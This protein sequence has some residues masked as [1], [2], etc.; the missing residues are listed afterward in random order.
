[1]GNLRA[2]TPC[3]HYYYKYWRFVWLI[4]WRNH[5]NISWVMEFQTCG[6]NISLY[7]VW[8]FW[9]ECKIWKNLPSN[10]KWNIFLHF[11]FFSECPNFINKINILEGKFCILW[12]HR[13]PDTLQ[14]TVNHCSQVYSYSTVFFTFD[15]CSKC[16]ELEIQW[17]IVPSTFLHCTMYGKYLYIRYHSRF[18]QQL[19]HQMAA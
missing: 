17:I 19:P 7:K 2:R 13:A 6:Y 5:Y 9:K 10:F 1:M 15:C 14:S 3:V 8:T 4:C 16:S 12:I 11:G 18:F